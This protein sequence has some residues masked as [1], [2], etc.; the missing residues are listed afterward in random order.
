MEIISKNVGKVY[1]IKKGLFKTYEVDVVNGLN[2]TIKQGEIIGLLGAEASGKS[3]LIKL[4]SGNTLPSS[5]EVLIDGENDYKKLKNSCEIINDFSQKQ[6]DLNE[7]VYNNLV[8]FGNKNKL[9]SLDVEK[10][11]STYR[12]IFELED[13]INKKI[14]ELNTLEL[15]KVNLTRA[16]LKGVSVLFFDSSLAELG[17]IEKNVVL[18][19][20]KRL[21]KE[22]KTTIVVGSNKLDDV[23]K[24]CK[25]LTII[26]KGRVVKDGPFEE[27]KKNLYNKKEIKITFNKT[28]SLPKGNFEVIEH[29]DYFLKIKINFEEFEFAK[30]INQFD[31][32]TIVDIGISNTSAF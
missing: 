29:D 14:S 26:N 15:I 13:S 1:K 6:L 8:S 18:K 4:L 25:R 3:T 23:E 20:L 27:L 28:Y 7:T 5:G 21:N 31:I 2:Y 24:I 17:T 12:E 19:L 30:L 11:I 9:D 16:M 10:N 22:N 32:N